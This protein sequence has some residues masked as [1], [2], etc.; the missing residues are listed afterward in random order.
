VRYSGVALFAH[1]DALEVAQQRTDRDTNMLTVNKLEKIIELEDSLRAEYQGKLDTTTAE[2]ERCQQELAEQ[3]EKLQGTVDTQLEKIQS[4][5]EKAT[6]NQKMEQQYRELGNRS[7]NLQEEV[8][9]LKKRVKTLQKDLAAEREEVN[10][11]KQYDALRMKK[12]LD[13]SKKKLAEKT[14]TTDVLQKSLNKS[15][16]ENS[17]LKRKVEELEAKLES[18]EPVETEESSEEEPSKEEAA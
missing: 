4:L 17:E 9:A 15:K 16:G 6:N 2:L 8:T 1:K 10:T 18:L 12:N 5:S 11:L 14:K 3:R 13:A 7:D